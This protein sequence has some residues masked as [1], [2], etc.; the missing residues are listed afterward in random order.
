MAPSQQ[1]SVSNMPPFKK[2]NVSNLSGAPNPT[3]NP[4]HDIDFWKDVPIFKGTTH[5]EPLPDVKNIMITGGAGFIASWLVRH[6]VLTYPDNYNIISFD[7]LDYCASLHNTRMLEK[8]P[9]FSF[10][11]GDITNASD[12]MEC[13]RMH[14]IDTVFHFAAQSHVDLSFGNSYEFTNTNVYGTHVLLESVKDFKIKRFVHISTDEVYG[15][16]EADGDD[17]LETS[18]LAPTNPYAASKAAAEMLVNAYYKSFKLPVVIVRSNNVYGPHQFPEKVIPKFSCLL[19]AGR[20]LP[21]HGDGKHA[22]RYLFAG[23][24]ADAF[25]TILHRGTVGQIYNVDSCDEISNLDL[26]AK[27]LECFNLPLLTPDGKSWIHHTKDRPFNDRRYAVD[28]SKLK[29]L[30]WEQKMPFEV[31]LVLTV[32][33]YRKYGRNWWG[34]ISKVLTPFPVVEKREMVTEEEHD[35]NAHEFEAEVAWTIRYPTTYATHA[36]TRVSQQ[37][38]SLVIDL[39]PTRTFQARYNSSKVALFVE[40]RPLGHITPLLLHMMSVVPPDWRFLFLGSPAS[41]ASVNASTAVRLSVASGKLALGAIE[42]TGRKKKPGIDGAWEWENIADQERLNRMLTNRTFYESRLPGVEWLFL[43]HADSILCASS[44]TSLN[45]WLEFDWVGAPTHPTDT[46]GHNGGLSLRR[47]SAIQKVLAFQERHPL[48]M[49][50]DEWLVNRLALLPGSKIANAADITGG[51]AAAAGSA[52]SAVAAAA[53]AAAAPSPSWRGG[54][55]VGGGVWHERP[56]GYHF[57]DGSVGPGL[58]P[59][60]WDDPRR[61][62]EV[63]AYC[64]EVKM[65]LDMKLERE[66]CPPGNVGG[67]QVE[68]EV[69]RESGEGGQEGEPAGGQ[70]VGREGEQGEVKV[71]G[72]VVWVTGDPAQDQG[73]AQGQAQDQNHEHNQPETAQLLA[74]DALDPAQAEPEPYIPDRDTETEQFDRVVVD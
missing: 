34:D 6:L 26:C 17:L 50:E 5:F 55:S 60:V 42:E 45:D 61:R 67:G 35:R 51:A 27:L 19:H 1:S 21:L 20:P 32:D 38:P 64:P 41:I 8:L 71:E 56:M 13:L 33:W 16:V 2:P 31:G 72:E 39:H 43:F 46:F 74:A 65:L 48:D 47:L 15:E 25:D 29:R 57:A 9:N 52:G 68:A 14:N 4:I 23:D 24:A 58:S 70:E 3:S 59:E 11:H 62:R 66:R 36:Y 37:L 49:S 69:G 44:N 7:K 28:G 73:E 40:P 63:L 12:V 22:R 18:L 10:F 53:A 30:G 54:F